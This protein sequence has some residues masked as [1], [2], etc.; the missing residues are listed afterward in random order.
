[1]GQLLLLELPVPCA[2]RMAVQHHY[3]CWAVHGDV[4]RRQEI[5]SSISMRWT[6]HRNVVCP[7]LPRVT[8]PRWRKSADYIHGRIWPFELS[9]IVW[10]RHRKLPPELCYVSE[11]LLIPRVFLQTSNCDKVASGVRGDS[12]T[13]ST[14]ASAFI[15]VTCSWICQ[16]SLGS[17][18][19]LCLN[20]SVLHWAVG[21]MRAGIVLLSPGLRQRLTQH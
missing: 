10:H 21:S 13:V 2:H 12:T 14:A 5:F 11:R 1:M 3:L 17:P 8:F 19:C 6:Y 18:N 20:N 7:W 9:N 4:P 16:P 15:F